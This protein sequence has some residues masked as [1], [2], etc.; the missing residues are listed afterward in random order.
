MPETQGSRLPSW[1]QEPPADDSP[2][3][4]PF[5]SSGTEV[6]VGIPSPGPS[7]RGA[8]ASRDFTLLWVGQFGSEVGNG[9]VQ[10]ALPLLVYEL[11]GSAF[12][13]ASAYIFQFLPWLLF[14]L[15]GGVLVDRWDRRVTIIVVETVRAAAFLAVGIAFALNRDLLTV[16]MIYALIFM[17]SSLQN[18][19][20]PARLALMPNLVRDEDL[21]AANSLMEVSRHIG[22][23]I[24]PSAGVVLADYVGSST[25]ILAD[26]VTFLISGVTVFFIKWRQPKRM[27]E[28]AA[29]WR[30]RVVLVARETREGISVILNVRILQVTILLG[31]VLNLVVAPI[32]TLLPLYV[33]DVKHQS[34]AYF[35]LLAAMF[36]TGLLLGSLGAPSVS[37]RMGL[38]RMTIASVLTLG[39][40][41]CIAAY[42]PTLIVPGAALIIAGIAIGLLNVSQVNMLQ[43]STTDEE[44]GRVS[45]AYYSATLGVRTV[46]YFLAGVLV[47]PLGV[48][49][50]FVVFGVLVLAVGAVLYREP[51]V[52]SHA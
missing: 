23:L 14:G 43:T 25:I 22:F 16:E 28:Q 13:L 33:F 12:Q 45:A 32:Q 1:R 39:A 21:R 2:Q 29:G 47:A 3:R 44:R 4:A 24:A 51:V 50:L 19:F 10:L 30:D 46:G 5:A 49:P 6:R 41:I 40:T 17:E 42:L 27:L 48:Q 7:F 26:G 15:L 31:F 20:N 11:T 8:L 36:V 9:L 38:G 18:F 52:R 37:Q 34:L 35:G